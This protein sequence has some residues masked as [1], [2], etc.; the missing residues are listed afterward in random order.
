MPALVCVKTRKDSVLFMV[1]SD[2]LVT[3]RADNILGCYRQSIA[4]RSGEMMFPLCSVLVRPHLE[5]GIQFWAP[6]TP[7]TWTY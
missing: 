1:I 6:T 3:K 2:L 4:S 7:E 5:H